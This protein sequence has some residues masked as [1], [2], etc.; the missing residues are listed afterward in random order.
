MKKKSVID[1]IYILKRIFVVLVFITLLL[2]VVGMRSKQIDLSFDSRNITEWKDG[3]EIY[4]GDQLTDETSLPVKLDDVGNKT[5]TIRKNLPSYFGY[6]N[7]MLIE[8]KRQDT[9]VY[10]RELFRGKQTADMLR[11]GKSLPHGYIF[12]PIN[13][14]DRNSLVEISYKTESSIYQGAIGKVYIGDETSIMIMLFRKNILWLMLITVLF[15]LGILC[16]AFR[17]IYRN[18]FDRAPLYGYLGTYCIFTAI[19]CLSHLRIR[20]FF[21]TDLP[22]LET[23][24]YTAFMLV[25]HCVLMMVYGVS[26]YKNKKIVTVLSIISVASFLVQNITHNVL[27]IDYFSMQQITQILMMVILIVF[28]VLSFKEKDKGPIRDTDFVMFACICQLA[29]IIFEAVFVMIGADIQTGGIYLIGSVAYALTILSYCFITL[30]KENEDKKKAELANQ[31]KSTFLANMSHEIRTPINAIIGIN[32]IISRETKE[33]ETKRYA[34]DISDAGNSL[35]TLVNDILDYSKIEAGKLDIVNVDYDTKKLVNELTVLVKARLQDKDLK[36]E[37]DI[38]ENLPA[39]LNGDVARIKQVLINLLTN[40]IK[41]TEKGG[42]TLTIK[43]IE[44]VGDVAKIHMSVEDTGIGIKEEDRKRL[45]G[46]SF[47]RLDTKKNYSVEGTGLGLSITFELLRL[48]GS[49]LIV[50]S[51]YGEGS[52]FNFTIEQKIVDNTPIKDVKDEDRV[53]DKTVSFT[54][55]DAKILVVDD[56][57][58]NIIVMKGLL[59]QYGVN[60]DT[61]I[62]GEECIALCENNKYDIIFLDHM[63]PEMDGV[64]TLDILKK[65]K[66]IDGVPVI[67]LTANAI[68]GAKEMYLDYGFDEYLSKPIK[69]TELEDMLTGFL[70][71]ELIINK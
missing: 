67:A 33:E 46:T 59:R 71:K 58:T 40:A 3:W 15:A 1:T 62:S 32:E 29:G 70:R 30:S 6:Y 8:T 53:K 34:S 38:D 49:E 10:I 57:R 45:L 20:Q 11:Q 25:P 13:A 55:P 44:M 19:F 2:V 18:V 22:M 31:A 4:I 63:M 16:F 23:V 14:T 60:A 21:I 12:I 26:R 64:D 39:K 42:F 56:T 28:I 51:I 54:C 50:D 47:V 69:L 7:S 24:G 5:V 52:D 27:N 65:R 36:F 68:S 37:T 35:L 43:C 41:Y 48:M 9:I 61:C 66:L 17:I